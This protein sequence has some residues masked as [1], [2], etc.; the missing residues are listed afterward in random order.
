MSYLNPNVVRHG[1]IRLLDPAIAVILVCG[2]GV[3]FRAVVGVIN[4]EINLSFVYELAK[5]EK[6][7]AIGEIGLDYHWEHDKEYQKKNFVC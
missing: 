7:K 1:A 4:K 2:A 6:V 3:V 5:E